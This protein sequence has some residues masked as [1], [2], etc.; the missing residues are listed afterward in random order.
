MKLD[1]KV[2]KECT[3]PGPKYYI[4]IH[5]DRNIVFS[6][7]IV[8]SKWTLLHF[9]LVY[10]IWWEP[11]AGWA[12]GPWR[13]SGLSSTHSGRGQEE[14]LRFLFLIQHDMLGAGPWLFLSPWSHIHHIPLR[15]H[16]CQAWWLWGSAKSNKNN[17][18]F[19]LSSPRLCPPLPLPLSGPFFKVLYVPLCFSLYH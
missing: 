14:M 9:F 17:I 10:E 6:R 11:V 12:C 4:E 19:S 13:G 8:F 18:A 1:R 7:C 2:S 15:K 5:S 16:G 3:N